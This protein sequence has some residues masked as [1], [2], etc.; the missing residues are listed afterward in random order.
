MMVMRGERGRC[1]GN[2]HSRLMTWTRR[3]LHS[4]GLE[5]SVSVMGPLVSCSLAGIMHIN[6]PGDDRC[7][8]TGTTQDRLRV[9]RPSAR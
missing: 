6:K 3:A 1:G 8:A 2:V 5:A 9:G 4:R 7:K